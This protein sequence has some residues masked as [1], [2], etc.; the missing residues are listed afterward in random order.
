M[1][2]ER[3]GQFVPVGGDHG[4]P[5]GQRFAAQL[6]GVRNVRETHGGAGAV[7]AG[8]LRQVFEQA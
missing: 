6:C 8:Q 2:G 4:E 1:I 3:P 7:L 5:L